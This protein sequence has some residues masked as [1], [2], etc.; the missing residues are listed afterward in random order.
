MSQISITGASTGTATFTIESPATST[1]RTLT[2]P[3]NTGTI[4]TTGTTTG[5]SAS[6][7][8]TGTLAAARLPAGTVL[9][10]VSTKYDGGSGGI[11]TSSTSYVDSN[12][13]LTITPSSASNKVLVRAFVQ[14]FLNTQGHAKIAIYRNDTTE[15]LQSSIIFTSAGTIA[16]QG[17]IEI[18]DSPNTTSATTYSIYFLASAGTA[19]INGEGNSDAGITAMEIAG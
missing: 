11:A 3:D 15:I 12:I 14:I 8:S 1:N 13:D 4:V 6:A 17:M 16:G 10:V 5:I 18:L 19:T 2:L 9:Q 7:L